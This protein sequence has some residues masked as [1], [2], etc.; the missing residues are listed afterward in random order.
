MGEAIRGWE[1]CEKDCNSYSLTKLEQ[2]SHILEQVSNNIMGHF[3]I[4]YESYTNYVFCPI[5]VV[6]DVKKVYMGETNP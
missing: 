5:Q 2:V 3:Y 6:C 4:V 1:M